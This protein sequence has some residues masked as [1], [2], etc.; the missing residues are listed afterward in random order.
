L[1]APPATPAKMGSGASQEQQLHAAA[2]T[3]DAARATRAIKG[4]KQSQIDHRDA[5]MLS[6][7]CSKPPSAQI[8]VV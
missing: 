2:K 7:A 6:F 5:V 8:Y 1:R 3:G 4:A